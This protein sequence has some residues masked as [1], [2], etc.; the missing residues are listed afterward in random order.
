MDFS[1]ST[2]MMIFFI[3][4]LVISI[5]K[6]YHFLPNKPLD[7]DDTTDEAQK[8]LIRIMLKIIKE[9]DGNLSVDELFVKM[10][11]DSEFDNQRYWRFNLNRLNQTLHQYYLENPHTSN[12]KEIYANLED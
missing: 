1:I 9:N 10:E 2:L 3:I 12:I 6:I 8:E 11:S 4:A 7:D 5:W